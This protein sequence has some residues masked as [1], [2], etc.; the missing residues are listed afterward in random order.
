M[1][2]SSNAL[3][4]QLLLK[5]VCI[6][7]ESIDVGLHHA[8]S[9]IIAIYRSTTY[10]FCWGGGGGINE[11]SDSYPSNFYYLY[12]VQFVLKDYH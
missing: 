6:D 1:Y 5:Q 8:V 12:S 10:H 9:V 7:N 4:Q 2:T 11:I 3:Q